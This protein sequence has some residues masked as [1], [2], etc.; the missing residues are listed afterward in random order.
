MSAHCHSAGA[1]DQSTPV[2]SGA[3]QPSFGIPLGRRPSSSDQFLKDDPL[4]G[5]PLDDD[6]EEQ[7][8][9]NAVRQSLNEFALTQSQQTAGAGP[10]SSSTHHPLPH[11]PSAAPALR[12]STRSSVAPSSPG[13]SPSKRTRSMPPVPEDAEMMESP[14]AKVP[15]RGRVTAGRPPPPK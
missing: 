12:R 5:P 10:S 6:H 3:E 2:F 1:T 9:M 4:L 13:G 11:Q 8:L 14:V 15:S 7:Q